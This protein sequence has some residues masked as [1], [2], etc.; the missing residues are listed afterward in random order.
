[1]IYQVL[2]WRQKEIMNLLSETYNYPHFYMKDKKV[3]IKSLI[4]DIHFKSD[5]FFQ[6][7]SQW[8]ISREPSISITQLDGKVTHALP[9]LLGETFLRLKE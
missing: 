7:M 6:Y 1:M 3:K 9:K 8:S 4:M 2:L 5:C